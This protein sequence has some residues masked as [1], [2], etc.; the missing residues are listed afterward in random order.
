MSGVHDES[1]SGKTRTDRP[2]GPASNRSRGET[3]SRDGSRYNKGKSRGRG[4]KGRWRGK[5]PPGPRGRGQRHV[6]QVMSQLIHNNHMEA[7]FRLNLARLAW[8]RICGEAGARFSEPHD[9]KG[10]TMVVEVAD[11]VWLQE[12]ELTKDR[13]LENMK[14]EMPEGMEPKDIRFVLRRPG[15][16]R[17]EW[18]L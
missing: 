2:R 17:P 13:L 15:R 8:R 5:R 14:H 4:Y 11:S 18:E 1:G 7:P 9:F 12:L 16:R 10:E 3:N 6:G